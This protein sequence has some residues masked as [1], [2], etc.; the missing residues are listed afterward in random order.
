MLAVA[1]FGFSTAFYKL[2]TLKDQNKPATTFWMLL[3]SEVFALV[4]FWNYITVVS[5]QS[6]IFAALWGTSFALITML[7]IYALEHLDTNVLFPVTTTLSL[8]VSVLLGI[9]LFNETLSLAQYGGIALAI[10]AIYLFLYKKGE[11]QYSRL[12]LGV[13]AIIIFLSVFNKIVQKYA[14]DVVEIHSY[15]I[16]QYLFGTV[17]ALLVVLILNKRNWKKVVFSGSFYSGLIISIPAFFG[18]WA[19]LVALTK[20]PFSL[21]TALHSMYIFV[22][23]LVGYFIFKEKLTKKKILL[24]FLALISILIIRLG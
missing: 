5:P 4:F 19:I 9:I 2:P 8:V 12:I 16:W 7:Q 10:V 22:S 18:G 17:F 11:V 14:A 3:F 20:G 24:I 13:G 1:L 15:M 21:I 6:F 23:A